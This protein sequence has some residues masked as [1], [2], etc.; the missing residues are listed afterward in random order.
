MSLLN[1]KSRVFSLEYV[2]DDLNI[3]ID[4]EL[5]QDMDAL[6]DVYVHMEYI[7]PSM[8][9]IIEINHVEDKLMKCRE[10]IQNT[11]WWKEKQSSVTNAKTSEDVWPFL[12]KTSK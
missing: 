2:G 3:M 8:K 4:P 5:A 6:C 12:K 9:K 7:L 11:E 1:R 10:D